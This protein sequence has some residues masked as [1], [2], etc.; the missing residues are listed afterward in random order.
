MLPGES[1]LVAAQK[2]VKQR[3]REFLAMKVYRPELLSRREYALKRDRSKFRTTV[4]NVI[5]T[6]N[7][8]ADKQLSSRMLDY[9][10][11][12]EKFV[13]VAAK[14][15][16]RA[17]HA[18]SQLQE[19]VELLD[20]IEPLRAKEKSARWLANYDLLLAQCHAY[21]LRLAQF[22]IALDRQ[23]ADAKTPRNPQSNV[24]NVR[25]TVK[26]QISD[27]TQLERLKEKY[28]K[29]QTVLSRLKDLQQ[30]TNRQF[31]FVI[32]EHPDTPWARRA[33]SETR[34]GFGM[35]LA[36]GKRLKAKTGLATQVK[37][38]KF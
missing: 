32:K 15:L 30:D 36:E 6:L 2:D 10:I 11:D 24:W 38:P 14:E 21:Q 28:P 3:Q 8:Y 37:I 31:A 9:P 34:S 27:E 20:Q 22:V 4:W 5:S 13:E 23:L 12:R 25:R 29:L 7:S 35:R 16:Q 33:L 17:S 26:L 18:A 1:Q 19:A